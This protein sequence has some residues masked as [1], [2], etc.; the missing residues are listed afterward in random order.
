MPNYGLLHRLAIV[1]RYRENRRERPALKELLILG[2]RKFKGLP[3]N[4]YFKKL[5]KIAS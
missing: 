1:S 4:F 3:T 2:N 5:L